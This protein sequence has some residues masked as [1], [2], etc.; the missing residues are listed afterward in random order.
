MIKQTWWMKDFNAD[1]L[2]GVKHISFKIKRIAI[3]YLFIRDLI[4]KVLL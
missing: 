2:C 4:R 3:P 1:M